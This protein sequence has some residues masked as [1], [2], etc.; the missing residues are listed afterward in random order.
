V[1]FDDLGSSGDDIVIAYIDPEP[2]DWD[3]SRWLAG[4]RWSA[5][6]GGPAAV[7]EWFDSV[8]EAIVWGRERA[9]IV[10]VRLTGREEDCYSAGRVRAY[11]YLD[12]SGEAYPQW[13]PPDSPG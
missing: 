11:Q 8:D 5:T 4:P 1:T 9:P 12:G 3:G 6:T 7:L 13:P 10:L 2:G